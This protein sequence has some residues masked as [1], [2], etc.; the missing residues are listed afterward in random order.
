MT[1][2]E[3]FDRLTA[4]SLAV[5]NDISQA[6][7][8]ASIYVVGGSTA[9]TIGTGATFIKSTAFTTNGENSNCTSDAA[10]DKITIIKL[11]R[12]RVT[13]FCLVKTNPAFVNWEGTVFLNNVE[14]P[15]L[16]WRRRFS[17]TTAFESMGF[18]EF[19][20]VTTVPWDLDFRLRHDSGG[21][22]DI[23]IEYATLNVEYVGAT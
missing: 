18:D 19:V 21:N 14:Q 7:I 9:Q 4:N 5:T 17:S 13:H 1:W 8:F 15:N 20:D 3:S 16:Y 12:Y 6:G 22:V 10:N 23:T 11:G 2:L